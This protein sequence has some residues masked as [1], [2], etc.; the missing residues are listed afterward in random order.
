MHFTRTFHRKHSLLQFI[1]LAINSPGL[2]CEAVRELRNRKKIF[3]RSTLKQ[4]ECEINFN[5]GKG[6]ARERE[7]KKSPA[8]IHFALKSRDE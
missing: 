3:I 8:N 6:D 5:V 4:T 1:S 7:K 2:M